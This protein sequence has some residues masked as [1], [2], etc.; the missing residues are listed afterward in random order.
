[1]SS[2]VELSNSKHFTAISKDCIILA[3]LLIAGDGAINGADF[4]SLPFFALGLK[5]KYKVLKNRTRL[6]NSSSTLQPLT[7]YRFGIIRKVTIITVYTCF[8]ALVKTS[9]PLI[10]LANTAALIISLRHIVKEIIKLPV[11]TLNKVHHSSKEGI[12]VA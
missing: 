10:T 2:S 3:E 7:F 1:M 6:I 8:N 5:T 9:F 12:P 4:S 11:S